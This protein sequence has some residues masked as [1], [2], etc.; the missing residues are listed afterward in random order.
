MNTIT[1]TVSAALS[2]AIEARQLELEGYKDLLGFA[3]STT[4]YIIPE[5]RIALIEEKML[6]TKA[7]YE[8]LK[9]EVEESI[10]AEVD[11]SKASWSL[12]FA[13]Q[14]VTVTY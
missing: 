7:E 10:P 14:V 5:S 8:L 1:F 2:Q 13:T 12:D 6:K 4:Q 11:R 9:K 3:Y